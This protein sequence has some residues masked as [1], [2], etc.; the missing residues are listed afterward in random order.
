MNDLHFGLEPWEI[1]FAD[2]IHRP[3]P[4]I[5]WDNDMWGEDQEGEEDE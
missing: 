5:E 4:Y 1:M 3:G 2:R